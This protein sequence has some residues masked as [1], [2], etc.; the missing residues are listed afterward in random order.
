MLPPGNK[1]VCAATIQRNHKVYAATRLQGRGAVLQSPNS[2]VKMYAPHG[3]HALF[4]SHVHTDP[5]PFLHALPDDEC[6]VSPL[7]EYECLYSTESPDRHWFE[8]KVPHCAKNSRSIRVRHG[9]IH[10]N[11]P[12]T[13]VPN[14]MDINFPLDPSTDCYFEAEKKFITIYTTHFSQ[15]ICSSCERS[16]QTEALLFLF[17]SMTPLKYCPVKS[18]IRLY[19][20]SPLYDTFD[21]QMVSML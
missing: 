9:D 15:F 18:A 17:G 10:R 20:C 8:L 7:V 21:Y 16:C 13:Q 14:S 3:I 19:V 6:L 4:Q 5:T 1:G 11:I 12:F 2:A